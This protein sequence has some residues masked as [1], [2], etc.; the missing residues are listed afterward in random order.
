[1]SNPSNDNNN[2]QASVVNYFKGVRAEW[3]KITWPQKQQ[4]IVETIWVIAITFAFTIYILLLDI[5]FK[6]VFQLFKLY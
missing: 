6:G 1:M 4:V 5:S 3:G 2:F